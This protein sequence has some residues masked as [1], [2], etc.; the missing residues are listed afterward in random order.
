MATPPGI[1][2][3]RL[4][5]KANASTKGGKGHFT[6]APALAQARRQHG[7]KCS[8]LHS[9]GGGGL[10]ERVEAA[11]ID[12]LAL[13]ASY[14]APSDLETVARSSAEME[15]SWVVPYGYQFD[16][17]YQR[18]IWASAIRLLVVGDIAHLPRY[19]ADIVLNESINAGEIT[20]R[21]RTDPDTALTFRLT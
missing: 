2:K 13:R 1:E 8:F 5:L 7:G 14:L 11:D 6:P 4:T 15:Q 20:Y 12:F 16:H 9:S 10:G 19:H 3:E 21:G 17:D 18:I